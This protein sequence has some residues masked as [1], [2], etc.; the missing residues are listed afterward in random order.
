MRVVGKV[1]AKCLVDQQ[2]STV[3]FVAGL[4]KQLLLRSLTVQDLEDVDKELYQSLGTQF[5]CFTGTKVQILT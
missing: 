5:P 3:S 4:Y 2:L 1:L